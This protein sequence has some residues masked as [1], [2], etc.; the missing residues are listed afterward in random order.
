MRLLP[1]RLDA[2]GL[3]SGDLTLVLHRAVQD[4]AEI[5]LSPTLL[6]G[7]FAPWNLRLERDAISAFDWEYGVLDALPGLDELHHHWQTGF[8]LHGW[9]V[10]Q[11]DGFLRDWVSRPPASLVSGQAEALVKIYLLHGLVQ[12]LETGHGD[13]DEMVGRYFEVLNRRVAAQVVPA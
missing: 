4:L 13:S 12:R 2:V 7:D 5:N 10:T 9:S 11:A 1:E 8:L 6:H 3:S